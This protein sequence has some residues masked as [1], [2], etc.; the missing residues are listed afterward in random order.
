MAQSISCDAKS[1][2]V[3]FRKYEIKEFDA[4]A[5]IIVPDTHNAIIVKDGI[6]LETL[7]AGKYYLFDKKKG[8]FKDK[9]ISDD[10]LDI[11][12]IFIS[13]TA[14]LNIPWGTTDRFDMRDPITGAAIK[15]GASGEFEVQI[16]NPRKA[17]LE[18][19][20]QMDVFDTVKLQKRLLGRLLAKVQYHLANAMKE[21]NLSYDRLGEI[22]LPMSEEILPHIAEL[23]DKDYGLKVFSFTIS[24]V[25]IDDD[26]TKKI[27]SAK[28]AHQ[29][30]EMDKA[31][32][33]NKERL[34][35]IAFQRQVNLRRLEQEDYGKY[36]E[37]AKA[38]GWPSEK[39][40]SKTTG[41]DCP[42]CGAKITKDTKFCPVCG[43]EIKLTKIKC[44]YC[45]K[46]ISADSIYCRHCGAKVKE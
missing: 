4:K 16:S 15:L 27:Q 1:N 14:K 35:E 45:G 21:K 33:A 39:K 31:E 22:L 36:L 23:F 32:K 3:L 26:S 40:E 6:A 43:T 28:E 46:A 17:Y 25:L 10:D 19:I 13:K 8:I 24:R 5:K 41:P 42:N 9:E 2:N 11:Q 34:D 38:I 20:G 44:P 7:P 30:I 37:V 29:K 18:L 12:V